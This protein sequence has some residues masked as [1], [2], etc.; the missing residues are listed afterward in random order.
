MI[1]LG[2]IS[3][4]NG[5]STTDLYEARMMREMIVLV[6][7]FECNAFGQVS[8]LV[9]ALRNAGVPVVVTR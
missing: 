2:G 5:L 3:R 8:Q 6:V 7:D 1:G 4:R 9:D